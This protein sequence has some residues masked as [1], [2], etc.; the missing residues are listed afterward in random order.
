M[1]LV[2]FSS[3]FNTITSIKLFG[4]LSTLGL[5]T[6]LCHWILDFLTNGRQTVQIDCHASSTL[7][8]NTGAPQGCVLSPLLYTHDCNPRHGEITVW[9][10]WTTLLSLAGLPVLVYMYVSICRQVYV[11]NVLF[12]LFYYNLNIC[13]YT[14]CSVYVWHERAFNSHFIVQASKACNFS[15]VSIMVDLLEFRT[16]PRSVA[17][18]EGWSL[19][20]LFF[21]CRPRFWMCSKDRAM[22][23]FVF[24]DCTDQPIV[25]L[26]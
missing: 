8:L 22:M 10:L 1:L 5:S 20:F 26:I 6:T 23:A 15:T 2:D 11:Y 7:V 12:Y 24:R 17:T 25:E 14:V 19:L 9:S 21:R 13:I 4:K 3:V 16:V 18:W